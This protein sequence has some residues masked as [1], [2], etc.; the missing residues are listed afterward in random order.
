MT[1]STTSTPPGAAGFA[2]AVPWIRTALSSPISASS[3]RL[4]GSRSTIWAS[5]A[6]S[7]RIRKDTAA[8]WRRRCTQPDRA[9]D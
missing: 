5:P 8:S 2:T 3:A 9:T 6:R 1:G 4:A 7:R